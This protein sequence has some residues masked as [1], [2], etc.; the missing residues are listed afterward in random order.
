MK[1]AVYPFIEAAITETDTQVSS[2]GMFCDRVWL[3]FS[4]LNVFVL[5]RRERE[6]VLFFDAGPLQS[7]RTCVSSL[8]EFPRFLTECGCS[9]SSNNVFT[10]K[11]LLGYDMRSNEHIPGLAKALASIIYY[12]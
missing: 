1:A 11:Y 5:F 4:F 8:D 12:V 2:S 7:Q 3:V 9:P 10:F 6:R